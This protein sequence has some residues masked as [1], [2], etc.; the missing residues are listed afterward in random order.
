MKPDF[1]QLIQRLSSTWE[2]TSLYCLLIFSSHFAC[3]SCGFNVNWTLFQIDHELQESR[4]DL[5][6]ILNETSMFLRPP[7][8]SQPTRQRRGAGVGLAA[9]AAVGIFGDGVAMGTSNS[10][11]L[12][13]VFAGCQDEAKANA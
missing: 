8:G 2:L 9:L 3:N 7:S 6:T 10:S 12:R 5:S 13:G 4:H 11:G 1:E